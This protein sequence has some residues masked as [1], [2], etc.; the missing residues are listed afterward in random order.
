M[1]LFTQLCKAFNSSLDI[2]LLILLLSKLSK[3][4]NAVSKMFDSTIFLIYQVWA[5]KYRRRQDDHE[6]PK[7]RYTSFDNYLF[8]LKKCGFDIWHE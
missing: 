2:L 5:N 1:F 6:I 7:F 4:E 3:E 8:F